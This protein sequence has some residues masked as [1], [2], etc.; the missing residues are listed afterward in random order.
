[1]GGFFFAGLV[2][3]AI[4]GNYKLSLSLSLCVFCVLLQ[5]MMHFFLFPFREKIWFL[6]FSFLFAI[7]TL[8]WRKG[9]AARRP[10]QSN[11]ETGRRQENLLNL[12]FFFCSIPCWCSWVGLTSYMGKGQLLYPPPLLFFLLIFSPSSYSSSYSIIFSSSSSSSYS[13][14]SYSPSY[15]SFSFSSY[16]SFFFLPLFLFL[17]LLFFHNRIS[18]ALSLKEKIANNNKALIWPMSVYVC[19]YVHDQSQPKEC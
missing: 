12:F 9:G 18:S 4:W 8:A 13:S 2:A 1:M 15:S 11:L 6:F 5:N 3:A 19:P 10:V 7:A 14:S 16:S 17:L